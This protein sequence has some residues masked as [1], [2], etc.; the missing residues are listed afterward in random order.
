LG[1]LKGLDTVLRVIRPTDAQRH[2]T[3]GIEQLNPIRLRSG[4]SLRDHVAQD[5][6]VRKKLCTVASTGPSVGLNGGQGDAPDV[7][8]STGYEVNI[9]DET[10]LG[11]QSDHRVQGHSDSR[12]VQRIYAPKTTLEA[13]IQEG[14]PVVGISLVSQ[15]RDE[16]AGQ[17][18]FGQFPCVIG[19]DEHRVALKL[20][21][22]Q[23]SVARLP[24]Q[25]KKALSQECGLPSADRQGAV[26]SANECIEFLLDDFFG[27]SG[28]SVVLNRNVA[29]RASFVAR[30]RQAQQPLGLMRP[31]HSGCP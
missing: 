20:H 27:R 13:P 24:N 14:Q 19:V 8:Q 4:P 25:R 26:A 30:H 23:S 11:F 16:C 3:I 22:V 18:R 28:T 7:G 2:A 5:R 21:E 1:A 12:T 29:E 9:V 31:L 10:V 6:V 17:A 15:Q